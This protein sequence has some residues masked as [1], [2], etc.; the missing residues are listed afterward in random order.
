MVTPSNL[1]CPSLSYAQG[2]D[3]PDDVLNS[4]FAQLSPED[5]GSCARVSKDWNVLASDKC[6]RFNSLVRGAVEKWSTYFGE[7][8]EVAPLTEDIVTILK[9]PCPF[10]KGKQVW[11]THQLMLIPKTVDGEPLTLSSLEKWVQ[12][13]KKGSVGRVDAFWDVNEVKTDAITQSYW[14]LITKDIV[15]NGQVI[16][17]GADCSYNGEVLKRVGYEV[18][19]AVE[20]FSYIFMKYVISRTCPLDQVNK[21]GVGTFTCCKEKMGPYQLGIGGF[22]GFGRAGFTFSPRLEGHVLTEHWGMVAVRKL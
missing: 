17:F 4:I 2:S 19:G 20:A 3:L 10:W 8:G 1:S 13:P 18:S 21:I 22:G 14:V 16:G 11:Q 7:V 9:G 15:P 12:A 5:L 6:L